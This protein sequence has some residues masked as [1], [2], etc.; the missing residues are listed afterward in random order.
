MLFTLIAPGAFANT[1]PR[2]Q[3]VTGEL[4]N[5]ELLCTSARTPYIFDPRPRYPDCEH[6]IQILPQLPQSGTFHLTGVDDGFKLPVRRA[7]GSC[8]VTVNFRQGTSYDQASWG[9][10]RLSAMELRDKCERKGRLGVVRTGGWIMAG[11]SNSI[12]IQLT[13]VEKVGGG[14][15]SNVTLAAGAMGINGTASE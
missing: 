5:G 3:N 10:I 8:Q 12:V 11:I 1:I 15:G 7:S 6:A 13:K 2:T 9:V 14:V 4:S